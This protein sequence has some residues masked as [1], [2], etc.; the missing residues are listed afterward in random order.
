MY[1]HASRGS[2][3]LA[4]VI[5]VAVIIALLIFGSMSSPATPS[6]PSGLSTSTQNLIKQSQGTAQFLEKEYVPQKPA[7]Q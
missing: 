5:V 2:A 6:N 1:R 7:A 4:L 3:W